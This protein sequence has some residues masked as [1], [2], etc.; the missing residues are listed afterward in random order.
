MKIGCG[1][2]TW[3]MYARARG[4]EISQSQ[5]LS[6]IAQAGYEGVP[7][8]IQDK[9]SPEEI[10]ESLG[11]F[12]LKPAPGYLGARY[13]EKDEEA[14]ILEQAKKAAWLSQQVGCT[15]MYVA[16]SPLTRRE[17][18]GHVR[19]KDAMP[20]QAYRQFAHALNRVGEICLEYGVRIGFHN[21]VGSVIETR[22]EIDKLFDLV[23]RDLVFQGPDIGH[24]AWAGADAVQF[25]RDYAESIVTMH[26]K[27]IDPSVLAQGVAAGWDYATFSQHGIFAE[28]GE[29]LVDLAAIVQI[30]RDVNYQGW[31]IVETDETQKATPL[32][33]AIIS[34]N[35]LKS[36]GL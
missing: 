8:G 29:G 2:I 20:D 11:K 32:E 22:A 27:D 5:I 14:E 36:L 7:F 23:D 31:F 16:A 25:C 24:L 21:H 1:S 10:V 33:S 34:R 15:E 12:G 30:L 28:L 35:Y 19:P 9:R 13:W 17:A 3:N 4:I 26:V 6:E 18:S